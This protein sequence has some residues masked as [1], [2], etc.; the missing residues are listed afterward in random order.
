MTDQDF[1]QSYMA[2]SERRFDKKYTIPLPTITDLLPCGQYI[3]QCER[4]ETFSTNLVTKFKSDS[5]GINI[6]EVY[7]NTQ[8]QK[9]GTF[10]RLVGTISVVRKGFPFLF[11]DAAATNISPLTAEKEPL[12]TRVVIHLPQAKAGQR[13]RLM[14]ALKEKAQQE[15]I[16]HRQMATDTLP[17]YWGPVLILQAKGLDMDLIRSLRDIAVETYL[18]LTEQDDEDLLLDYKQVQDQ[19]I[20]LSSER[21]HN[22]FARMGLTVPA[23]AQAAFFSLLTSSP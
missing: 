9:E 20:F 8:H 22:L 4:D 7:K 13:D 23:E 21:E 11:L 17:D 5:L 19:M 6:T 3:L 15:K 16:E 12:T 1:I 18:L 10:V 14:N 2:P